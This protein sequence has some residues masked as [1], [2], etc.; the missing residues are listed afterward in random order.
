MCVCVLLYFLDQDRWTVSID[1]RTV[2]GW[3]ACLILKH[4]S[5][6]WYPE[7]RFLKPFLS[8]PVAGFWSE[9][10]IYLSSTPRF[11]KD[12]NINLV[13]RVDLQMHA[14]LRCCSKFLS[15]IFSR[16]FSC[17]TYVCGLFSQNCSR[18]LTFLSLALLVH[19]IYKLLVQFC[20]FRSIL[21][22]D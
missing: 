11:V 18:V 20:C 7:M 9:R 3:R 13:S 15:S 21:V 16:G 2:L 6:S 12:V 4:S 8:A 17:S 5:F 19:F 14:V 1:R 10:I 22:K